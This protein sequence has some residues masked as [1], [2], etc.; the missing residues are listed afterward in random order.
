VKRFE[1]YRRQLWNDMENVDEMWNVMQNMEENSEKIWALWKKSKLNM[2]IEPM[3]WQNPVSRATAA[4]IH[5]FHHSA[6]FSSVFS[7]S[8]H[9]STDFSSIFSISFHNFLLY[10]PYLFTIRLAFLPYFPN[11]FTIFF[12][13]FPIKHWKIWKKDK[14]NSEMIWK[15]WKISKSNS[16]QIW[17]IQKKK[18]KR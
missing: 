4:A 2:E 17:N 14:L 9:Y 18:V 13:I 12:H 10:F 5:S 1:K 15:I 3:R 7:K 8:F 6:Y 11:H 16:E